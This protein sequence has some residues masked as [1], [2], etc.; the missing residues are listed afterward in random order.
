VVQVGIQMISGPG[1]T[2]VRE[3][4]TPE[5]MGVITAIHSHHY[6]NAPYG[7]WMRDIPSDCDSNH[8]DWK[9][10]QGEAAPAPFDPQ[11]YVNWRFFWDY[12]GGIVFENMV[13]QVGYWHKAL[14][15]AIPQ[16]VTMTGANCLS[17][18][19]QPPDVM[20]VTMRHS[21]KLLF[22]WNSM[23]SND[24]YGEGHDLLLG[25]KGTI[26]HDETDKPRY[27][28]QGGKAARAAEE[29]KGPTVE[30]ADATD[31]HMQNFFDCVRSR[32]EPACPFEIGFRS[33][34]ACQMAVRSYREGRTVTWDE[35][36]EDIV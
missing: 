36:L 23:F 26:V 17:P 28:P 6:R 31:A 33:A 32:K 3:F 11:R 13:H 30:Y 20:D 22:T 21:D 18:K 24:Y 15:L 16:A 29:G 2:M 5:R 34:I 1:M 8:V 14:G 12:S 10:F 19:M 25:T 27:V 7:G 4:A 35:K 9:A